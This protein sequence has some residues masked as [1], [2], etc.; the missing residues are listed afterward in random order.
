METELFYVATDARG[1]EDAQLMSNYEEA[2]SEL[3]FQNELAEENGDAATYQ[4]FTIVAILKTETA[5][6]SV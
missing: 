3:L 6:L 5:K 4:L 2:N 1:Y